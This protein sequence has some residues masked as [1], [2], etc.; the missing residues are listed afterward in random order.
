MCKTQSVGYSLILLFP[1][2]REEIIIKFLLP[3]KDFHVVFASW[4]RSTQKG[5]SAV[6][7]LLLEQ[8]RHLFWGTW[9]RRE[10]WLNT[11]CHGALTPY[12]QHVVLV[13]LRGSPCSECWGFSCEQKGTGDGQVKWSAGQWFSLGRSR[14]TGG[15]MGLSS[16]GLFN[17]V[18]RE[19]LSDSS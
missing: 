3:G 10:E 6:L 11:C 14:S 5:L 2:C 4:I 1:F 17:R 12:V 13:L 18:G 8:K 9:E 16:G 19:S 15:V 7:P